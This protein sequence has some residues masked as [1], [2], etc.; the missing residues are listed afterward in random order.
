MRALYDILRWLPARSRRTVA[1][2]TLA[3]R[4][5]CPLLAAHASRV[6]PL[7]PRSGLL[8]PSVSPRRCD[9]VVAVDSIVARSVPQLDMIL[10]RISAALVEGGIFLAT[11]PAAVSG[12]AGAP[13]LHEVE[14][15]YRL[16]RA[17]FQGLRLRRFRR[18]SGTPETILSM[19]VRRACN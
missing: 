15:Q 10:E 7:D 16:R 4:T 5:P 9:V 12:A 3:P 13:F 18:E 14:L 19:A 17:G 2:L 11:F 8:D 1:E 6:V